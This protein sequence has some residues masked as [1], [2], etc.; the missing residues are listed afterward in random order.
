MTM[1]FLTHFQC[2]I[3]TSN[4]R[5]GYAD[6]Y[7]HLHNFD[8][9]P[10]GRRCVALGYILVRILVAQSFLFFQAFNTQFCLSFSIVSYPKIGNSLK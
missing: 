10:F 2:P 5:G 7:L 9:M 1:N 3:Y 4:L 6:E 8:R